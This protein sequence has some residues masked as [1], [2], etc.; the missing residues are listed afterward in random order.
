MAQ[1]G[2]EHYGGLLSAARYHRAAHQ[3]PQVFQV[4][5]E[6]NRPPLSCGE[7]RVSFVARR[8]VGAIPTVSFNT[9][10]GAIRV[11]S[12]E[13]TAFDVVGYPGH[14]GGLDNVATVLAE[15]VE[16][17]APGRLAAPAPLS[18]VPWA[19]RLG[20]LLSHVD[21]GDRAEG[22]A[23][24]VAQHARETAL[25]DPGADDS[26]AVRDSRWKLLVNAEVEP[27]L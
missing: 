10:R 7:V 12:P 14:A 13:A 22:L 15:L 16:S 1:L 8:N 4:M 19:Q 5:V 24:Y 3:Q 6:K 11:S 9:P 18:P 21:A 20:F 2:L 23:A 25:L 26:G 27:D 17:I